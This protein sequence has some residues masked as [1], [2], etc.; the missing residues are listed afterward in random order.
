MVLTRQGTRTGRVEDEL[1]RLQVYYNERNE[2]CA[3]GGRSGDCSCPDES[4]SAVDDISEYYKASD[5][6]HRHR[7]PDNVPKTETVV[8]YRRRK[9]INR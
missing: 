5:S 1:R 4:Y 8:A 6:C 2:A 3:C 9:P 7:N